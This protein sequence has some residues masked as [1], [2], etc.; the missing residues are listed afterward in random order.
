MVNVCDQIPNLSTA[1]KLMAMEVLWSSLHHTF[2]E[3]EP[4]E[5]HRELLRRR[6]ELIESGEAVYEDWNSVKK[7]LRERMA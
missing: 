2:E 5:W 6:R 1:E 3:S 4:P 7:D